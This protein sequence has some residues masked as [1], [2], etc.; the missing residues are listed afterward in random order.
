LFRQRAVFVNPRKVSF[1]PRNTN[2]HFECHLAKLLPHPFRYLA[3][4]G[5]SSYLFFAHIK[6]SCVCWR[7]G[8][9]MKWRSTSN[10]FS[11]WPTDT[12]HEKGLK[13]PISF[14]PQNAL[15][16]RE[17]KMTSYDIIG[18]MQDNIWSGSLWFFFLIFPSKF[19]LCNFVDCSAVSC[20]IYVKL[21]L[22]CTL[23]SARS[24]RHETLTLINCT[25]TAEKEHIA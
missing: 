12:D 4:I 5:S 18:L 9:L 1:Y 13:I 14:W 24:E 6:Y 3:T 21:K 22:F 16:D 17:D 19:V 2:N 10:R 20:P 25:Q 23:S 15:I 7:N 8:K 11:G